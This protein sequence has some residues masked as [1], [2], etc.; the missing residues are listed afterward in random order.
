MHR[1]FWLKFRI[2]MIAAKLY[3]LLPQKISIRISC[4]IPSQS[5]SPFADTF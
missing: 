3:H 1:T 4:I 2:V 5:A